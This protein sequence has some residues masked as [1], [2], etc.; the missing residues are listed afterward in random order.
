[1]LHAR[2]MHAGLVKPAAEEGDR[3]PV[4]K[5]T[6][7]TI[8]KPCIV[9]DYTQTRLPCGWFVCDAMFR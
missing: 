1:M 4:V 9:L 8:H 7:S 5:S 2:A 6:E 3:A